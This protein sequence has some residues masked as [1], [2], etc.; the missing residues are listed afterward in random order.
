VI[1]GLKGAG[2]HPVQCSQGRVGLFLRDLNARETHPRK[3]CE[4]GILRVLR[5]VLKLRDRLVEVPDVYVHPSR[6]QLSLV[7]VRR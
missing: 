7:H 3:Q 2:L 5:D 6:H 1:P 4:L